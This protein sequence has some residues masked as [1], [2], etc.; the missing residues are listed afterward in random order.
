M[1]AGKLIKLA[2]KIGR[3]ENKYLELEEGSTNEEILCLGLGSIESIICDLIEK[4]EEVEK[5]V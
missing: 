1:L 5:E 3:L 4:V 2:N